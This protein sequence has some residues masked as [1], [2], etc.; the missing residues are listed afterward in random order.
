VRSA[1]ERCEH[2]RPVAD[3]RGEA[4]KYRIRV[5]SMRYLDVSVEAATEREA[6]LLAEKAAS[7]VA[8]ESWDAYQCATLTSKVASRSPAI[9]FTHGPSRTDEPE[10][11]VRLRRYRVR[12]EVCRW[13]ELVV[14]AR[15]MRRALSR[16][17]KRSRRVPAPNWLAH[18]CATTLG[19]PE[20]VLDEPPT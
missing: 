9:I 3:V 18:Q 10:E 2:A 17:L 11:I 20:E 13:C 15:T 4:M 5:K 14:G 8:A 16:A 7:Q 1:T 12:V 6:L 19:E